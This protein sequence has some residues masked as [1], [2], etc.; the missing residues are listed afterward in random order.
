M[1]KLVVFPSPVKLSRTTTVPPPPPPEDV[2]EIF[3]LPFIPG[4][5]VT[6]TE[7]VLMKLNAFALV[8]NTLFEEI[9]IFE[10][11]PPPLPSSNVI[12]ALPLPESVTAI[13]TFAEHEQ[14]LQQSLLQH[15]QQLA[16][17]LDL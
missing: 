4:A 2:N 12:F 14:C 17:H 7:D 10:R 1:V 5:T 9:A 6:E 13:L 11:V 8:A 16:Q 15:K 3:A